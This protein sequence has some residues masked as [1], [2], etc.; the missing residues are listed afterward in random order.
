MQEKCDAT[1]VM[2]DPGF[3]RSAQE[4]RSWVPGALRAPAPGYARRWASRKYAV[5][6]LPDEGAEGVS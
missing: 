2:P 4:L 6:R 1:S 5:L 3:D